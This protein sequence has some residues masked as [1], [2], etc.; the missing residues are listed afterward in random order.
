MRV[1]ICVISVC[2]LLCNVAR[3]DKTAEKLLADYSTRAKSLQTLTARIDL[4]WQTPGQPLKRN[5]G[6]VTL[7]KPN[8][9]LMKL[10][11]DYPLVTIASDGKSRYL[12]PDTSK[13]TIAN[14][15]PHGKNIDSPWWALPVRFFFTQ[16]VKPFGPDSPG[17]TSSRHVGLETFQQESYTVVEVAGEKPM[18]YVA[19]LYFDSRKI[20]RRSVVRF[21]EGDQAA[22]FT[23]QIDDVKAPSRLRAAAFKFTPPATAKLDTGAESKMLAVGDAGP[24]FF[25]PTPNGDILTLSTVRQGK[26]AT[27]VNFWFIACP[28]CRAEFSLFQELYRDLKDQGFTIV[29]INGMDA[30]AE[31]KSY[32]K[33]SRIS[34][35]IVVGKSEGPGVLSSYRIQTYPSTYLLNSQGKV[36][37]KSVGIDQAGLL[38]ALKELGLQK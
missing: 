14:A 34:F 10:S 25:L 16:D 27:L 15:D 17:W 36:V 31:I 37:Y 32:I 7:L 26:K 28:P 21:G 33:E 11:G 22:T 13:Y 20:L 9:A 8:Y 18:A 19:R 35:P 6:T 4:R 30:A 1:R 24:E 5:I 3:G 2:L 38:R 12:L 23:A 29:A